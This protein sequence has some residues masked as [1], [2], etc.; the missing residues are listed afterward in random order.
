MMQLSV[1]AQTQAVDAKQMDS[2]RL[3]VFDSLG[4]AVLLESREGEYY[5]PRIEVPKFTRPAQEVTALLQESWGLSSVFLFSGLLENPSDASYFAAI[6]SQDGI[7]HHPREM[8]WFT[9]HHAFSRLLLAKPERQALKASYQKAVNRKQG[10]DQEPFCRVGWMNN[11]KDWVGGRIAPLGMKIE[12]FQQLNGCETFSLTRFSTTQYP[13]WFKAVGEPNLHEYGISQ[14]L[15]RLLPDYVPAIIAAKPEWHGWLMADA[16]G[17]PLSEVS[18]PFAWQTAVETL[19][20]IQVESIGRVA[21]LADAGCRRLGI[22]QLLERVDPFLE[23]MGDLMR[24]QTKSPPSILSQQ[25][26]NE[27]GGTL[28]DALHCMTALQIPE[29]LG[30]SDFNPGNIIVGS[31]R[32]T[33]IDWAEAHV[34]HPFLTF[35]YFL[36]HVRK[37]YPTMATFETDLRA[38]YCRMWSSI[39]SAEQIAEAFIFS[40]LMAVYAYAA[41]SHVWRDSERLKIPGFQGYLRSLTRRMKREADLLQ[42]RRVECPN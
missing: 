20:K 41:G 35:E 33:F 16:G 17:A 29:T 26:L 8:G 36:A 10:G 5:L 34:G 9:I 31:E 32:C 28:K 25:D 39:A 30:H 19:G 27:L 15:A 38:C 23:V 24:Q 42:R 3:I 21:E 12:G 7:G 22:A 37:D 4:T 2:Y 1:G 18:T 14:A 6:E 40:P 11:L 13:V